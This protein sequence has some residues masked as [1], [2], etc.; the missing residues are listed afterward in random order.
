MNML[1]H[2]NVCNLR[3]SDPSTK[4]EGQ[5]YALVDHAGIPGLAKKLTKI[6]ADWVSLF[7]GSRDEGALEVAPLLFPIFEDKDLFSW[8]A[9][10]NWISEE[11]LYSTSLLF[12]V[13]P[14][15]MRE[16]AGRLALRLDGAL[17]DGMEI[18]LR[19]FDTRIFEQLLI[20]LSK[21]QKDSF[22]G[23]AN[24]WWY[25]DRG[26]QT[27]KAIAEFYKEDSEFIPLTFDSI[28]EA[29]M[30][31]ASEPDQIAGL[32]QECVPN[33]YAGLK[34]ADRHTFILRNMEVAK[35]FG[36]NAAHELS[37]FC[38]LALLH[39]ETFK[40]E[41]GWSQIMN[42]VQAGRISLTLAVEN[43]EINGS[44]EDIN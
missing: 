38:A 11:G 39:G 42:K 32:L 31:D 36:I 5:L 29:E 21:D 18:V 8:K 19:Y 13:S 3:Y 27:Q 12:M 16:L 34:P 41:E 7:E 26:G 35:H 17:P 10:F 40:D 44:N 22:L 30:L 6:N 9:L 43:A 25:V 15:P 28:Q 20:T 37:L 14:L 4:P 1:T 24:C 2:Q 23:V 33:E